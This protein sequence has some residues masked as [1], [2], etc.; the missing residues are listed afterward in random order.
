MTPHFKSIKYDT[1]KCGVTFLRYRRKRISRFFFIFDLWMA[2]LFCRHFEFRFFRTMIFE[3]LV[4]KLVTGSNFNQFWNGS[5]FGYFGSIGALREI[6]R[7]CDHDIWIPR[8]KISVWPKFQPNPSILIC[9]IVLLFLMFP[10]FYC[11][12]VLLSIFHCFLYSIVFIN[13]DPIVSRLFFLLFPLLLS[14][15]PHEATA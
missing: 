7:A 4:Q 15:R 9:S 5:I 12:I 1:T 14:L 6:C 13:N 11:S 8:L 2:R 10:L 3:F